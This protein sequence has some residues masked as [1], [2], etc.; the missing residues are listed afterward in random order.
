MEKTLDSSFFRMVNDGLT[1]EDIRMMSPLVWAYVGD[2]VYELLVRT[3][4]VKRGLSTQKLHR[5]S[6]GKVSAKGQ[7]KFYESIK[8]HLDEEEESIFRRGR[9][10]H[11]YTMAKNMT[12]GEY[13]AATGLEALF[14]YLYLMKREERILK[15]FQLGMEG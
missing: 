11:S 13:R 15:L 5:L 3:Y 14:G 9:N 7:L 10:A 12:V 2:G 6:S 8:S 4:V 1:E